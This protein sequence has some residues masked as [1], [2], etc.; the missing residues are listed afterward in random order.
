M[1]WPLVT[2]LFG[3]CAA[4]QT[5]ITLVDKARPTKKSP[6]GRNV[7][8][9]VCGRDDAPG[10]LPL[11]IFGHGFDC[12]AR[13]YTWLCDASSVVTALVVSSDPSPF[14]PDTADMALDQADN[15]FVA[16]YGNHRMQV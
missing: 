15:L 16:E 4:W 10:A 7:T 8:A 13:D 9:V 1:K 12:L 6:D 11:Y 3:S 2:L 5:T 14:L